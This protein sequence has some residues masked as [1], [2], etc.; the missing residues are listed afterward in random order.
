MFKSF[1]TK[2]LT[3]TFIIFII[4]MTLFGAILYRASDETVKSRWEVNAPASLSLSQPLLK[5]MRRDT[6]D[7]LKPWKRIAIIT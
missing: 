7:L 1:V 6:N 4:L 3:L 5:K 2:A